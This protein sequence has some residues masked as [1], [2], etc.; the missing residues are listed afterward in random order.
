VKTLLGLKPSL[1]RWLPQVNMVG[2]PYFER[3]PDGLRVL[4]SIEKHD[5]Q[6]WYHVSASYHHRLPS[7]EDMRE[8]KEAFCGKEREA[9]IVLP[10]EERYI[11]DH[12]FVLHLWCAIDGPVLPDFRRVG[13]FGRLTL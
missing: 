1:V 5:G 12:K 3:T 9:Y 6:K 4:E 2:M 11:N 13:P 7:W 8:V 10:P